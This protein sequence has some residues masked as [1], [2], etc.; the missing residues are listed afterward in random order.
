M[1]NMFCF[2]V[3]PT[4]AAPSRTTSLSPPTLR[5]STPARPSATAP[6]PALAATTA[7]AATLAP[8]PALPTPRAPLATTSPPRP[9]VPL[10]WLLPPPSRLRRP[11]VSR[12][13]SSRCG[14]SRRGVGEIGCGFGTGNAWFF[15]CWAVMDGY[16]DVLV[17]KRY[18]LFLGDNFGLLQR[19]GFCICTWSEGRDAYCMND[20][21]VYG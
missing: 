15:G 2:L 12:R 9:A 13:S 21:C 10:A 16:L 1:T 7:P 5:P 17:G 19:R 4:P 6:P 11:L 8:P 18:L 20:E 3:P 14:T